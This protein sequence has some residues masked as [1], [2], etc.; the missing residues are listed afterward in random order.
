MHY[1]W[2]RKPAAE[3]EL[4]DLE[5]LELVMLLKLKLKKKKRTL[6]LISPTFGSG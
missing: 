1:T 6:L 5:F 2:E 4:L 3:M